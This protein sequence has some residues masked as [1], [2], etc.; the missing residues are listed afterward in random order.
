MYSPFNAKHFSIRL[1]I[2][3]TKFSR[4]EGGIPFHA[5]LYLSES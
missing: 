5:I 4:V 3:A 1:G 2:P